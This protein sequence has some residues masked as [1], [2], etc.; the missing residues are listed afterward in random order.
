AQLELGPPED[1]PF[2]LPRWADVLPSIELPLALQADTIEVDGLRIVQQDA[3]PIDITRIRGGIE[4]AD[5]EFR[6]T[7]LKV[8][9]NL[10]DF[11]IDGHY[12]PRE[13]YR[14]DLTVRALMPARP[15]QPRARLGL[16]A[17]GDLAH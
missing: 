1:K 17:R 10:G 4:A 9:G 8:A 5:G 13:D 3:P 14:T 7:Q 11:R 12:L 2:E 15:G 16:V 6:A